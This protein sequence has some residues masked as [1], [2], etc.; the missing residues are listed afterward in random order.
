MNA[1]L[2]GVFHEWEISEAIKQMAPLKAPGPDG[3]PP[4]FYQ[5]FWPLVDKDVT[6]SV[7]MWLN[8][9]ILPSPI[10]HTFITLVSKVDSPELVIEFRPISL[11][12]VLYKIFSKV[13]A[14]RLKK[15]LPNLTTEHQSAFAKDQLI[16]NNILAAFE[17]LHCMKNQTSGKIGFMARKLDMSK[18]YN[19]VEWTYLETLM[20]KMGFCAKWITLIMACVRSVTYSILINREP[21]GFITLSREI[22]QGDP[23]SPFLFLLCTKGLHGLIEDAASLGNLRGFSLCK[24]GPKL[25]HLFFCRR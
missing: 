2:V 14:N 9:G 22:G 25:T 10:N 11:G 18:A 12:N 4:L 15:F 1:D 5:H 24:R 23:L 7:L 8:L 6:S 19:R 3:M 13:L 20:L 21:Q 17:T 16:T